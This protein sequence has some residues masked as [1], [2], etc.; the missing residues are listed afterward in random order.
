MFPSLLPTA[1]PCT[2]CSR[3]AAYVAALRL[4][5]ESRLNSFGL[6]DKSPLDER[7][8][9]APFFIYMSRRG[10]QGCCGGSSGNSGS[11][12][13]SDSANGSVSEEL[14]CGSTN[15]TGA[16]VAWSTASVGN[17]AA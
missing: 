14:D 4:P 13:P 12:A 7:G 10:T 3:H 15:S 17:I 16:A 1:V 2:W 5:S 6:D 11:N 9:Y 8:A